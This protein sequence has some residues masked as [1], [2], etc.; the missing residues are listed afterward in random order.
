MICVRYH[1][2][3]LHKTAI[4]W[5]SNRSV[6]ERLRC[7]SKMLCGAGGLDFSSTR[8]PFDIAIFAI[9]IF[10]IMF[11]VWWLLLF[12]LYYY[13]YF[14][15]DLHVLWYAD[16]SGGIDSH[17]RTLNIIP[18]GTGGPIN[19][20]LLWPFVVHSRDSLT[21]HPPRCSSSVFVVLLALCL[22]VDSGWTTALRRFPRAR[23]APLSPTLRMCDDIK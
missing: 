20:D 4:A 18:I 23:S 16:D 6:S 15:E 2:S 3:H 11:D 13:F 1:I 5:D 22:V 12:L 17:T 19:I 7:S 14:S 21:C 10:V 8:K 9:D